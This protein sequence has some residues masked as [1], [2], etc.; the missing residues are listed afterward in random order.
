MTQNNDAISFLMENGLTSDEISKYLSDGISMDE[1]VTAVQGL[2]SR[3]ESVGA[4]AGSIKPAD[5]SDAGNADVF[6]R[7][8]SA[9]LIFVDSMGWLFWDGK[10]WERSEH[11]ALMLALEFSE[12]M[13]IEAMEE[14]TAALHKEATA[15][16]NN[17]D[18]GEDVK[19]AVEAT[20]RA[21]AYLS[22]AN[23][24]RRAARIKAILELSKPGLHMPGS[25]MDA[26]PT[27][28]NTRAGIIDLVTGEQKHHR[29]SSYCTMITAETEDADGA[30]EAWQ[31]FLDVITCDDK[32]LKDFL[33]MVVGM[34]LFGKVYHEGIVFAVGDG[35][36]GKSTFFNAV[37]AVLGDYTGYINIDVITTRG[38]NDK[39]SLATLRGKRMVIAGELEEGR[40]LSAATV[41]KLASTDPFQV[42]E[43]YKQP[44]IIK[45]SHTLFLFTNHLP[46]VGSTDLGT[47]R[48]ILNVPFNAVIDPKQSVQN[49]GDILAKHA[50]GAILAWAVEGAQR[51]A[52]NN[53]HLDIPQ[54]V[55]DATEAYR[56]RESWL[57]NFI[58]ECCE[59]VPNGRI[60][61]SALYAGYKFRAE[62]TR[63]PVRSTKDFAAEMD[64]I[65]RPYVLSGGTKYYLGLKLNCENLPVGG[66]VGSRY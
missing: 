58:E 11:K 34:A 50:G 22:H 56:R 28:L 14:Y 54:C 4:D 42:E 65:G 20:K 29:Q 19:K 10:R 64:R 59:V 33:Q 62:N 27:E 66:V 55:K 5:Y 49:F 35:R 61:A 36:N 47:W 44:E 16:A 17:P 21:K 48:R 9:H 38:S 6:V 2:V 15:K 46:R 30:A 63:E 40:R 57:E 18:G 32:E 60:K 41:K 45:P 25:A 31:D 24:T 23:I 51:F 7:E 1:L 13:R 8:Y 12:R 37:G 52:A 43:K 26:I 53:F 39:A 3:R